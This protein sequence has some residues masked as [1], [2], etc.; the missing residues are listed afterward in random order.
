MSTILQIRS[1][2]QITL[3]ANIRRAAKLMEGDSLKL[4][5]DENGVIR[6]SP[7]VVVDRTQAYFLTDQWQKGEGEAEADLR[8]GRYKDFDSI[9]DMLNELESGA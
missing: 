7:V 8:A 9:E 1:N 5:I 2:G 4:E 6:L 3:P